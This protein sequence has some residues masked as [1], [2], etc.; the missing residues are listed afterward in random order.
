MFIKFSF[1]IIWCLKIILVVLILRG[2]PHEETKELLLAS[3]LEIFRT[4]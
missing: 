4:L 2:M 3:L 1:E